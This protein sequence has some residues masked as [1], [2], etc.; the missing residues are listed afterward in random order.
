MTKTND[1]KKKPPL[2]IRKATLNDI[3]NII[4]LSLKV[5]GQRDVYT[6]EQLLGHIH[7]FPEGQLVAEYNGQIVGYCASMIVLEQLA[8]QK[9]TWQQITG[10]GYCST[11]NPKGDYLYGVDVFV[12]PDFRK[13]RIG[14]RFY[15]MRHHLCKKFNL[16]GVIFAGRMSL[17][18]QKIAEVKTP[19][20]YLQAVLEKKIRDP[21]LNFQLRLGYKPLGILK[22]YL[23]LDDSSLG[24]AVHM[25]WKNPKE[26]IEETLKRSGGFI[27]S[28]TIRVAS[29]QY[30]QRQIHSFEEFKSIVSYYVDVAHDYHADFLLFPE[31]FALQL[32]SIANEKITP[33][34]A[35]V[36]LTEYTEILKQFFSEIAVKYNVN[37]I[38]GS[39]P[40]KV[41]DD[42]IHNIA[43][44]FL[45]DGSVHEQAKIHPTPDEKYWWKIEGGNKLHVIP[46][47][48]GAIGILICY[49][50]EFPELA[51]HLAD[52]GAH[53][54][55]VPFCTAERQGY[56]RVRYCAHARAIENQC[57]VV[58]AGNVGN[59]PQ[60]KNMDIQ[61]AQSAIL[62]PCDFVFSRDGIA[63]DSTPNTEMLIL[64]DLNLDALYESRVSGSVL[65]LND[66]R[67][68]LFSVIWHQ[69]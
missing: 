47:D 35:I 26:S 68:E 15:K 40:T 38:A 14:E 30:L 10:N 58:L 9:H 52:Q 5:Y 37:I 56:L 13:M 53:L 59:L 6:E 24:N 2:T 54:I 3:P 48:C 17:L 62:T 19:E 4:D 45:R 57:Y 20:G 11:H 31:L 49:D 64:A 69:T 41:A 46:T 12:D 27:S 33:E 63:A 16:K 32:L 34:Q 43:Y 50:A 1:T 66:R 67:H 44:V 23:P 42:M 55:F 25:I 21:V 51:R 8:M 7:H 60:V 65:N 29:V 61:Y 28:K 39:H 18:K 22:N 36:Q